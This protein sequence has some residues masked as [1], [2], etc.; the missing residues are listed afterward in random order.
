MSKV[1]KTEPFNGVNASG[2]HARQVTVTEANAS[3]VARWLGGS[4]DLQW[5]QPGK[6]KSVAKPK[7]R[8]NTPKGVRVAVEGDVVVKLGTRHNGNVPEFHVIKAENL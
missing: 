7:L 8:I 5:V 4:G 6:N 1:L 2:F 3:D